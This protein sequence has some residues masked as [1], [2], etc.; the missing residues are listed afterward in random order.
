MFDREICVIE[1]VYVKVIVSILKCLL[2][3][4]ILKRE[5]IKAITYP[6]IVTKWC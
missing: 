5:P 6:E 1:C 2:T 4:S 3:T